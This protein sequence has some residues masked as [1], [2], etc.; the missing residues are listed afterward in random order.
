MEILSWNI[1]ISK[2]RIIYQKKTNFRYV[3]LVPVKSEKMVSLDQ[4]D[5]LNVEKNSEKNVRLYEKRIII[6]IN[7]SNNY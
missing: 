1:A 3:E 7:Q 5:G 4:G 6:T 2:Q